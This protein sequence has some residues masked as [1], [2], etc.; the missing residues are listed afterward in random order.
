LA[1]E[2]GDPVLVLEAHHSLWPTLYGIGDLETAQL[3]LEQGLTRYDPRR[4]RVYASIYG[5]QDTGLC[6]LH[7]AAV[8]AWTRGYPDKV[9]RYNQ[10]A[11]RLAGEIARPGTTVLALHYTA[12]VHRQRREYRASVEKAE[13]R[14]TQGERTGSERC[15]AS[16]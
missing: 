11:L 14:S 1:R 9:L 13:A 10:E 4:H 12:W 6:R 16:F 15:A 2:L 3:H 5:G 7:Y 8:T